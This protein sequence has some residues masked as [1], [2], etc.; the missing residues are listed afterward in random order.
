MVWQN[1]NKRKE[2]KQGIEGGEK[3]RERVKERRRER[4]RMS[5]EIR[6][7]TEGKQKRETRNKKGEFTILSSGRGQ[8]LTIP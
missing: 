8:Q 3:K 5:R 4:E 6:L 2:K 7:K 1:I